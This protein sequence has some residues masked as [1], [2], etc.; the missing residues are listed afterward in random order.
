MILP[1]DIDRLALHGRAAPAVIGVTGWSGSGKTA[2]IVRLIPELAARGYRVATVKHA[3]HT[4]EIDTPGKDS[5]EHRAAGASEV[6][7]SSAKRWAIMHENRDQAEPALEELV[8][9]LSPVDIVLVEGFKNEKHKKIEVHRPTTGAEPICATNTSIVAVATDVVMSA[10][11][12][13]VIPV[14]DLNDISAIA[15]FVI[16]HCDLAGQ[17]KEVV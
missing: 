15:D 6:I 3:H 17:P 2:L 7:V 9:K 4:F 14:L 12:A 5:F 13:G 11:V 8:A 16:M 1:P 10:G